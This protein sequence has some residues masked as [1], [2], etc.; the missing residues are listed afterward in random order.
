MTGETFDGRRA[1]QMRLV[2]EAVPA[3]GLRQRTVEV[4]SMLIGM[5]TQVLCGAK[6]GFRKARLMSWD[7][8]EE[9]LY[10][11]LDQT[12][13][14]DRERSKQQGLAQFLDGKSYRPGLGPYERP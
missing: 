4:A 1:A 11:K 13:L 7:D 9:Y 10:A 3:D 6:V 14:G 8:A 2:N 5:N 12:V